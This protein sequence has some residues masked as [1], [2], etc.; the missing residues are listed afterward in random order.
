MLKDKKRRQIIF[1]LSVVFAF[2]FALQTLGHTLQ[3]PIP[4]SITLDGPS[5][6]AYVPGK[7][8]LIVD[9][10]NTR[11][12]FLNA[13]GK[14]CRIEEL[15]ETCALTRAN[16]VV[17]GEDGFYVAGAE[18]EGGSVIISEDRVVR[19][20]FSGRHSEIIFSDTPEAPSYFGTISDISLYN[21]ELYITKIEKNSAGELHA[22]TQ[23]TDLDPATEEEPQILLVSNIPQPYMAKY[24]PQRAVLYVADGAGNLAVQT[25][26]GRRY[27]DNTSTGFVMSFLPV[28][29]DTVLWTDPQTW[30]LCCNEAVVPDVRDVPSIFGTPE[31][32]L[33]DGTYN[34]ELVLLGRTGDGFSVRE[35]I[36]EIAYA[37][38]FALLLALRFLSVLYLAGLALYLLL[39]PIWR[40]YK[41]K[42]LVSLTRIGYIAA[43]VVTFL[44]IVIFYSDHLTKL[45]MEGMNENLV[46]AG[47]YFAGMADRTR[48]DGMEDSN[49]ND[50]ETKLRAAVEKRAYYD[51]IY[52]PF[53]RLHEER[54]DYV[55]VIVYERF[56]DEIVLDY[57]YNREEQAGYRFTVEEFN[58]LKCGRGEVRMYLY[59]KTP[60]YYYC[61][62]IYDESGELISGITL[63][64]G[65]Q[66]FNRQLH[67]RRFEIAMTLFTSVSA[68]YLLVLEG[69]NLIQS[70]QRRK[71]KI[72]QGNP[73][74]EITLMRAFGFFFNLSTSL[75]SVLLVLVAKDMLDERQ[76]PAEAVV[77][78]AALPALARGT[79]KIIGST[80][81][82]II[83]KYW[84]IRTLGIGS[85]VLMLCCCGGICFTIMYNNFLM[86]CLLKM[87]M[88]LGA[89]LLLSLFL[90]IS[91]HTET[92]EE[93][94]HAKNKR[95]EGM[96]SGWIL[97][98]IL[99]GF[100]VKN[101][102]NVMLYALNTLAVVPLVLLLLAL[103]KKT[104]YF[105]RDENGQ[106]FTGLRSFL[107]FICRPSMLGYLL[108]LSMPIYLFEGYF[109]Y[110]FPL[111][112]SALNMSKQY[113][114]NFNVL[115]NVLLLLVINPITKATEKTDFWRLAILLMAAVSLGFIGFAVSPTIIWAIVM[116]FVTSL[117]YRTVL[118]VAEMLWPRL[119]KQGDPSTEALSGY[120]SI[121]DQLFRAC[122]EMFLSVFLLF[123]ENRACVALGIFYGICVL[124]FV[125]CTA[126]SPMAKPE[127]APALAQ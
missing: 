88:Y 118:P 26:E 47:D 67:T 103:P 52:E 77:F 112:S 21:G 68:I 43:V 22:L 73:F 97:G 106:F 46:L 127:K 50:V 120:L 10:N 124:M 3:I 42:D 122:K 93:G 114:T 13:G 78:L 58:S 89:G 82:N 74:P 9:S 63:E 34:G 101:F 75:D 60:Y 107:R 65:M 123:G 29:K 45:E 115:A 51:S 6:A 81:Y 111:Y 18:Q 80:L 37:P 14:V 79:G 33:L 2:I 39:R 1:V 91:Y 108:C 23:K 66:S 41:T 44:F 11:L 102:S 87:L 54:G 16:S 57:E 121:I 32:P 56:G 27:L 24:V 99:G 85:A 92:K 119:I 62:P 70:L 86:F 61:V 64:Q 117:L 15:D 49:E 48:F 31:Y 36:S 20:D 59:G 84:N 25:A 72:L 98:S 83:G 100:A 35:R 17:R 5:A 109:S 53:I 4:M 94:F 96:I 12:I 40:F 104:D 7:P 110:I 71:M 125:L 126:K 90:A 30:L 95:E 55:N 19:Y 76:L 105:K 38:L 8:S 113:V 69:K 116:L 28:D